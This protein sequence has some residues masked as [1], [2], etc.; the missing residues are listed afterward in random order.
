MII[1]PLQAGKTNSRLQK[2]LHAVEVFQIDKHD[3]TSD[4]DFPQ[5]T[6]RKVL[7]NPQYGR[8]Y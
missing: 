8:A 6:H 2:F 5:L 1:N 7:Q 4:D 3:Q